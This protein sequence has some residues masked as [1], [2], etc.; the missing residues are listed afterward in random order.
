[1]HCT[2]FTQKDAK[3]GSH[4]MSKFGKPDTTVIFTD[5]FLKNGQ[6]YG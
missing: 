2:I 6:I 4:T 3:F 5:G 1:M